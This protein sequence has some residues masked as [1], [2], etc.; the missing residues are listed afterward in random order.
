MWRCDICYRDP[1]SPAV[2]FYYYGLDA[3]R[4]ALERYNDFIVNLTD[5]EGGRIPGEKL[6]NISR[7]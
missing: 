7:N 5:Y 4:K 3:A 6:I 1:L 2:E